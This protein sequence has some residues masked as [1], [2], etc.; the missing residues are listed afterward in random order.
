MDSQAELEAD[1]AP[2]RIELVSLKPF[3]SA[4]V[5]EWMEDDPPDAAV[6]F[7]PSA[8]ILMVCATL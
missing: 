3:L 4:Y 5:R 2:H 6:F 8:L 1:D 7:E